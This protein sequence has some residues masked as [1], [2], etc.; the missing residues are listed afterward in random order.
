MIAFCR[1][2]TTGNLTRLGTIIVLAR[3]ALY[4]LTAQ[5]APPNDALEESVKLDIPVEP[6]SKA[7]AQF[8]AQ[9]HV[10]IMLDPKTAEGRTAPAVKGTLIARIALQ[11]L[12]GGSGLS[13]TARNN[14]VTIARAAAPGVAASEP[15]RLAQGQSPSEGSNGPESQNPPISPY[16]GQSS[17]GNGRDALVLEEVVV[18]GTHISGV[19]D[20]SSPLTVVTRDEIARSGVGSTEDVVRLLPQNFGG[21]ITNLSGGPVYGGDGSGNN[22]S[23]GTG[24][25]LRGLGNDST[26]VLVNGRRLAPA[27][28]GDFVDV[29]LIPLA[30]IDRIEVLTDGASAIYGSD[31]VGGVVNFILRKHYDGLE[32][33]VRYGTVTDGGREDVQVGQVLGKDWT[34]GSV[35]LSADYSKDTRLDAQDRSFA[36]GLPEPTDLLP[37]EF[38]RNVLASLAQK[39]SEDAEL[40]ADA[41]YSK[42]ATQRHY[43]LTDGITPDFDDLGAETYGGTLGI[44]TRMFDTWHSDVAATYARTNTEGTTLQFGTPFATFDSSSSVSVLEASLDGPIFAAPGGQVRTAAGWQYRR[45]TY[46]SVGTT[47]PV[48]AA[49]SRSIEA[50][51]LEL[52]VPF[53]SEQEHVP[54]LQRLELSLAGRYE[55]YSDFGSATS[56]KLGV[57]WSPLAGANVRA[58]FGRSFRAPLLSELDTSQPALLAY[59]FPDVNG[60]TPTIL[61]Q[62]GNSRLT[63]ETATTWTAG[64]D[65]APSF[66]PGLSISTNYFD[67]R[68]HDRIASPIPPATVFTALVNAGPY[69]AFI[70]RNPPAAVVGQIF[71]SPV[72]VNPLGLLPAQIGAIIDDRL[73]NIAIREENGIDVAGRYR[74]DTRAGQFGF[75]ADGTYL[76]RLRDSVTPS[77][78]FVDLANT[79]FYPVAF[80]MRDSVDWTGGHLNASVFLN[81]TNRYQNPTVQP[82]QGISS[83]T[84]V[85]TDIRYETGK[86][87]GHTVWS[88][89]VLSVSVLN[90]FDRNPPFVN[91]SN[92]A[93]VN[94]DAA[95]A[96][97]LNRFVAVQ[98]TKAW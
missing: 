26:L 42:H 74:I 9:A 25:N 24:I 88:N 79:A 87:A 2:G 60:S 65:F 20:S 68:F 34:S 94:L 14:T 55:H 28:L 38:K 45:E 11:T 21:G 92:V 33:R 85:D 10:Q 80:K 4:G 17:S 69:S 29:S 18:T 23:N 93:Q 66:I 16:T 48:S 15:F 51:F 31:A 62:G 43:Y 46:N 50:G 39:I 41:V 37:R 54:A 90:L 70:T 91:T 52:L 35:L 78:P 40:F 8:G 89:L 98:L 71:A 82:P 57:T 12:L 63:P 76:F 86:N 53:V 83:W 27:G 73:A 95:N 77:A 6:L 64:A 75:G 72:L 84:T 19:K 97:P 30:A 49:T 13:Y 58:T 5:A 7:L 67:I 81:Y 36:A 3:L 1:L 59:P 96:T 61:L 47:E 22:L 32:T 44:T 56:P